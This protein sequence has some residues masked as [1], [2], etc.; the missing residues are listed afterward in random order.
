[1]F[2]R[3][4]NSG[5]RDVFPDGQNGDLGNLQPDRSQRLKVMHG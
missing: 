2:D 4:G 3:G 1:M 5:M